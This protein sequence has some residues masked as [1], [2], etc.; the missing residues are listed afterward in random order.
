[1]KNFCVNPF[2]GKHALTHSDIDVPCCL[3]LGD[4]N[5]SREKLQQDFLHD[6]KLIGLQH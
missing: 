5:F 2:Y 1:M 4:E 3:I 6:K